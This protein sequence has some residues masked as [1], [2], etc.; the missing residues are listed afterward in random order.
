MHEIDLRR[1]DLNL[2]VVFDTLMAERSVTRAAKRLARTQSAVSHALARLRGQLDDPLLVK[3][4]GRMRASP[5]AEELAEEV[6]AILAATRRVLAA[7]V[8]FDPRSSTRTFRVAFP[9]LTMTWFGSLAAEL[10]G[11][12]PGI[13]IEWVRRDDRTPLAVAEGRVDL[14]LFPAASTLPEGVAAEAAG[15]FRWATFARRGHPAVNRWGKAEWRAHPHVAVRVG[16]GIASPIEAT[17][18]DAQGRRIA[19]WVP[20]FAAVAPLLAATNLLATLPMIA[21]ADSLERF[22]LIALKPPLA[23]PPMPHRLI[24][25]ERLGR[26]PGLAW[27]RDHVRRTFAAALASSEAL[28]ASRMQPGGS[29]GR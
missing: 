12:A 6:R 13:G 23:I 14:A 5:R 9:D 17:G 8:P 4:G 28:V 15:A 26:E 24:W 1:I 7:P 22:D 3:S 20:H 21:V 19:V 27:L 16:A 2:L 10:H 11:A 18:P 29:R 25:S